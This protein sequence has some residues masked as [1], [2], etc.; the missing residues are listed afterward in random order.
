MRQTRLT[1][2]SLGVSRPQRTQLDAVGAECKD[3]DENI[4]SLLSLGRRAS[5]KPI[6]AELKS[7]EDSVKERD[8][9]IEEAKSCYEDL[10]RVEKLVSELRAHGM[11]NSSADAV[12]DIEVEKQWSAML[13]V[14][15]GKH[16]EYLERIMDERKDPVAQGLRDQNQALQQELTKSEALLD[17]FRVEEGNQR[18]EIERARKDAKSHECGFREREMELERDLIDARRRQVQAEQDL[19]L[20][21]EQA[22]NSRQAFQAQIEAL[23]AQTK[24]IHDQIGQEAQWRGE[25]KRRVAWIHDEWAGEVRD[26]EADKETLQEH[27]GMISHRCAQAE[28]R[29]AEARAAEARAAEARAAEARAA[30]LATLLADARSTAREKRCALHRKLK[31]KRERI[32]H[33]TVQRQQTGYMRIDG[34]RL[35]SNRW[36][37]NSNQPRRTF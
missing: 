20:Y 2:K 29:A 7:L 8:A 16:P 17:A 25:A 24:L 12:I 15:A 35:P 9:R 18:K 3:F 31:Q 1:S 23:D 26:L 11:A 21:K 28:A 6:S 13:P 22:E 4:D 36:Q 32:E 14:L 19:G 37:R 27:L 5:H 33:M 30:E 10:A 34:S